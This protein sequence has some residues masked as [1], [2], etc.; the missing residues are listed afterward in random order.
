MSRIYYGDKNWKIHSVLFLFKF[1]KNPD[2]IDMRVTTN[3]LYIIVIHWF[4]TCT[5]TCV[6]IFCWPT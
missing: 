4:L 3:K 1:M 5:G 6:H 2:I